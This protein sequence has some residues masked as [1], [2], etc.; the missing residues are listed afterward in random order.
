M[1]N[2]KSQ[3]MVVAKLVLLF[4]FLHSCANDPPINLEDK[5]CPCI[6]GYKCCNAVKKC[7]K[8]NQIC[9]INWVKVPQGDFWMGSPASNEAG[10]PQC[11]A[12]YPWSCE[13]EFG[14][15]PENETLHYVRLTH[16]IIMTA[17][18]ITQNQFLDIMGWNPS[19]S[20]MVAEA[21]ERPVE[22]VNWFDALEFANRLS[23]KAGLEPCYAL[24]NVEKGKSETSNDPNVPPCS[25]VNN[26]ISSA[27][28]T[29]TGGKTTPYKCIGYRL[30]TEAEWEYAAR[31]GDGNNYVRNNALSAIAWHYQD[32][33]PVSSEGTRP[34]ATLIPN[35]WC[36]Y[37]MLG[38]TWE[39]VGD[40]LSIYQNSNME[41]PI[42]NPWIAP[43]SLSSEEVVMRGCGY[44]TESKYCR[45]AN[46]N[47]RNADKLA[48]TYG[49]R[50]VRTIFSEKDSLPEEIDIV[51]CN[52]AKSKK[53]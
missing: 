10:S 44:A 12:G 48:I 24:A 16:P 49:F 14:S 46:R 2:S 50:L 19:Y 29:L 5:R 34:V 28:V 38:N 33:P 51:E 36:L 40:I 18:E 42:I 31:A 8:N 45:F 6:E 4:S 13:V 53:Q 37:D 41:N 39:F 32:G 27:T 7:V 20:S 11:P 43:T 17:T 22:C 26:S 35:N 47:H 15:N 23:A 21:E 30:P 3:V 52:D 25:S 1:V 9:P